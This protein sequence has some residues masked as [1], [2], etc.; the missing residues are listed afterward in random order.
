MNK[1]TLLLV[2]AL[3]GTP[4][5]IAAQPR[6]AHF[7]KAQAAREFVFPRDHG[8]H[9]GFATEWWYFTG[10][11]QSEAGDAYGFQLTFFRVGLPQEPPLA[12]VEQRS[13]WHTEALYLAHAS[14]TADAAHSFTYVERTSRGSFGEAGA[15]TETL[16]VWLRDWRAKLN[17]GLVEINIVDPQFSL[18]LQLKLDKPPTLHGNAGL[19]RKGPQAGQASYYYS[20]TRLEGAGELHVNGKR[21]RLRRAAAWMDHEFFSSELD[22]SLSGW[23]WFAVQT[24][25]RQELMVYVLRR[26]DGT[27]SQFSSGTI[28]PAL[29]EAVR[30]DSSQFTVT[31]T[32][33]W[34]SEKTGVTYPS[35]WKINVPHEQ[36][37]LYVTPTVRDQELVTEQTT[38]VTY[39]EGRN[40]VRGTWSGAEAKGSAYVELVGYHDRISFSG[41]KQEG[42]AANKSPTRP[43]L[44]H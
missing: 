27:P 24:D 4:S 39:W 2:A 5:E 33:S 34:R 32:G 17:N 30:L 14:I 18:A 44:R 37:E 42:R 7:R 6:S 41:E 19:S 36:I 8:Q 20:L 28:I 1:L 12:G 11:L 40:S 43:L 9:P 29:G 23:D 3:L 25:A 22:E 13:A 15:S 26:R 16:D 38:G 21:L 35:G 31:P 10:H